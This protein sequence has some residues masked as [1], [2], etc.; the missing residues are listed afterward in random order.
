MAE[1]VRGRSFWLCFGDGERNSVLSITLAVA[2]PGL[3][4]LCVRFRS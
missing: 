1:V 4:E 3:S 2:L